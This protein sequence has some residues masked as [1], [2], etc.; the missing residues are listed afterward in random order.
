[1][2]LSGGPF[3]YSKDGSVFGNRERLLP[4]HPRG[5]YREYTVKTPGARNRG[6]RRIVRGG[7]QT[8]A[9]EAKTKTEE[10]SLIQSNQ[11]I[12]YYGFPGAKEMGILG[13]YPL[14]E[15]AARL[16]KVAAAYDKLNGD[17]GVIPA[18]HII[19]GTVWP[20]GEIGIIQPGKLQKYIDY[21][22]KNGFLVF[23]DHQLGKYSVES[24][25][26]VMLPYL[27]YKSVHLAIDPEWHTSV[28]GE[29]LGQINGADVNIAQQLMQGYMEKNGIPGKKILVVHQFN[30]TMIRG[31]ELVKAD[32]PRIDLIHNADGFGSPAVK[33]DSYKMNSQATNMPHKG[34]KLFYSN[35]WRSW[36]FDKP[37][38]TPEQVMCLEPQ[39]VLIMYQ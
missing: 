18:F 3:P 23:L 4:A 36:G 6:A 21:A 37:L 17:K 7:K 25:I 39:P 14:E 32:F 15:I 38:M 20:K 11:L 28:P 31:R 24:A 22:E 35:P 12:L 1:L 13:E 33:L 8:A 10:K 2:I 34:F 16:Q 5:F 26:S 27:K 30:Y 29:K 9:P 19:F